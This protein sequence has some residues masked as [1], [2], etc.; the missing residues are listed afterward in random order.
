MFSLSL[1]HGLFVFLV[2]FIP[3]T[4]QAQD[5][6]LVKE[7]I[8]WPNN[9]L[10]QAAANVPGPIIE[11]PATAVTP[12]RMSSLPLRFLAKIQQSVLRMLYLLTG[13][14]RRHSQLNCGY[15]IM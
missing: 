14:L 12:I 13:Y 1:R 10:G 7:W 3:L 6:N 9:S 4:S 11:T 8:F 2:L 5:A 15:W